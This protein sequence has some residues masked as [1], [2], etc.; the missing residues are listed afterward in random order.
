MIR[1]N[2]IQE[3]WFYQK[4][5]PMMAYV[6][7][8]TCI[9]DFIIFPI[10]WQI[11]QISKNGIVSMQWQPITLSNAGLYHMAMGAIIGI[12]AYGRT[13]EKIEGVTR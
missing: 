3:N 11:I 4:W 6:Y 8:I 13:K 1:K 9:T 7:M 12:T 10:A 2:I 5:R